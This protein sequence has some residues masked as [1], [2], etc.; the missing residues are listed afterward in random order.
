VFARLLCFSK[1]SKTSRV[2]FAP[3][4]GECFFVDYR[5]ALFYN[6]GVIFEWDENMAKSNLRKRKIGF[7][8]AQTIFAD[9]FW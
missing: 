2:V 8:E 5:G 7:E 3:T 9:F 1:C 4:N 6:Y